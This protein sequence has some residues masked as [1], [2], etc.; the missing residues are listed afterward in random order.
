MTLLNF[1]VV[2]EK[3]KK[4][5]KGLGGLHSKLKTSLSY[6]DPVSNKMK[7]NKE[8]RKNVFSI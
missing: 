8:P 1:Y 7:Q 5:A 6:I 4:K 2:K 3:K